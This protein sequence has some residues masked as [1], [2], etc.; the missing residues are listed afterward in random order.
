MTLLFYNLL[1]PSVWYMIMWQWPVTVCDIMLT[2]NSKSKNKKINE[3]EKWN[4]NK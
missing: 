2:S 1:Q 3:N 4:K